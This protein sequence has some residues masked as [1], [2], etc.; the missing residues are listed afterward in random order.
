MDGWAYVKILRFGAFLSSL[1]IRSSVSSGN[2]GPLFTI[3]CK[4]RRSCRYGPVTKLS[5][6]RCKT[7]SSVSFSMRTTA[8]SESLGVKTQLNRQLERQRDQSVPWSST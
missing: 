5:T 4:C 3:S 7:D 2:S 1:V 6:M 8:C